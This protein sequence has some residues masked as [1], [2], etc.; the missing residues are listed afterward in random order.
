MADSKN[1][2]LR[3]LRR[4]RFLSAAARLRFRLHRMGT[5]NVFAADGGE[6]VLLVIAYT[7]RML[8]LPLAI[9]ADWIAVPV[10]RLID[11]SETWWV[12]EVRFHGWDAEFVRIAEATT[13]AEARKRLA[14]I[15]SA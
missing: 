13:E 5:G 6:P 2:P 15:E 14:A 1:K 10:L 11:R 4:G 12:V 7:I 3:L 9:I 8:T